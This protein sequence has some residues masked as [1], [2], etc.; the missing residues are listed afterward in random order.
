M[1]R[2]LDGWEKL[3]GYGNKATLKVMDVPITP[4]KN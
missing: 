3:A 4:G 2:P 1:K